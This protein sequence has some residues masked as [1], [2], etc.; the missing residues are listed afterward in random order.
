MAR[1]FALIARAGANIFGPLSTIVRSLWLGKRSGGRPHETDISSSEPQASAQARLPCQAEDQSGSARAEPAPQQGAQATRGDDS[2]EV[3]SA[4]LKRY[5]FPRGARVRRQSEIRAIYR[6]GKRRR[7]G[8]LDV[9]VTESP[10]LRPRLALVVPKH[11]RKIVE[12][13]RLKRRLRECARLELMPRCFERGA[14]IDVL[15]RARPEAYEA[16]YK[17]LKHEISELAEQLCSQSS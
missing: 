16:G 6:R 11:G 3:G 8:H 5:R 2:Q 4:A 12:R 17:Q 14:A 13:N 7:T 1:L 10:A 15:I 9:F